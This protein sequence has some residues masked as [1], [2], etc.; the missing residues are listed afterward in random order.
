MEHKTNHE[1]VINSLSELNIIK[2]INQFAA[3]KE[4]AE[5]ITKILKLDSCET[6]EELRAI[7]NSVVMI[8][9]GFA[10]ERKY[11]NLMSAIIGVIERKMI[12]FPLTE[13]K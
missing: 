13:E 2:G 7:R 4:A 12:A 8:Y 11:W 10:D 1:L 6:I 9:S 3:S 5:K